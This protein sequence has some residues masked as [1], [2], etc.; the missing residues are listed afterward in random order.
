MCQTATA[1]S[2]QLVYFF[3]IFYVT[4]PHLSRVSINKFM[5]AL[6]SQLYT[7]EPDQIWLHS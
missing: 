5:V 2:W 6:M 1:H 7:N 4:S 3:L